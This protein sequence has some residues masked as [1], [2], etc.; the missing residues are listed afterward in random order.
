LNEIEKLNEKIKNLEIELQN[1]RILLKKAENRLLQSKDFIDND[2]IFYN[3]SKYLSVFNSLVEGVVF[4]NLHGKIEEVNMATKDIF[5]EFYQELKISNFIFSEKFIKSDGKPFLE[6]NQPITSTLQKKA[7]VQDLEIGVPMNDGTYKWV[8]ANSK[9]VYNI[10][11]NFSGMVI[12]F[13]DITN[14]KKNE[15]NLKKSQLKLENSE[16]ALKRA[17][18]IAHI[19]SWVWYIQSN[20]LDWSDEM[21]RIFGI[22]KENFKGEL[23]EI[24][25]S[26]IHPDDRKKVDESNQSV[27]HHKNPIPLEYRILRPDGTIRVVW[28]EAGDMILDENGH[29][30]I[31]TGILADIT[32]RKKLEEEKIKIEKSIQQTLRLESIGILAGGIAHDFN[33][34]LVGIYGYIELALSETKESNVVDYLKKSMK[35]MARARSL[36]DQLLTFSKSG[37]P[38]K[39]IVNVGQLIY[40]TTTF[41]LSGSTIG[42]DFTISDD[43]YWCE[44]DKNKIGQVIENIVLNAAQAMINNGKILIS[45]NNVTF[46]QGEH[47]ILYPG[48]YVKISIQDFGSGMSK[49]VFSHLFEPFFTTKTEG[50]GL[51]LATSYSIIKNHKGIIEVESE[52][53]IGSTFHIFLPASEKIVND[54][55]DDIVQSHQGKG[56]ILVL[57]DEES[58][59]NILEINL[60]YLGYTTITKNDGKELLAHLNKFSDLNP[61][62]MFLDLTIPGGLGGKDIINDLR[63]TYPDLPIFVL[64]GY[65]EDPIIAQPQKYGFTASLKKPFTKD[66]LLLLLNQF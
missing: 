48:K 56:V 23:G 10:K 49:D 17:Q 62:Y 65:A 14:R 16:K 34:L 44:I 60:N 37:V 35:S 13:V 64:S 38:I 40:E 28:G 19:G 55:Q 9:P 18:E 63:S 33:N 30:K 51:G 2:N 53:N 47:I 50:H 36:T 57:D 5:G 7:P 15:D 39:E 25:L 6:E 46:L 66:E 4:I 61:V 1:S 43:L 58:I 27:I 29:P 11:G 3:I 59:Q 41:T 54:E 21:F 26:A 31:L 42:C 32:E 24:M 12:S 20:S 52:L 45:A 22:K 8:L